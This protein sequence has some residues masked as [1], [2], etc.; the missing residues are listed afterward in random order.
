MNRNRKKCIFFCLCNSET[1]KIP[2]WYLYGRI[3]GKGASI[4]FT[5]GK[6]KTF[7]ES[8]KTVSV[9]GQ[10]NTKLEKDKDF[11]LKYGLVFYRKLGEKVVKYKNEFF[12][13]DDI[14]TFEKNNYFIKDY[15]WE[16]EKEFRIVII[17]KTDRTYDRLKID[18]PIECFK[19]LKI[20]VAPE[21]GDTELTEFIKENKGFQEYL[22]T[23]VLKS[24]LKI[25]MSLLKR[26]VEEFIK[27]IPNLDKDKAKQ[28]CQNIQKINDFICKNDKST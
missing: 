18:I 15:P 22:Q 14:E 5:P 10:E 26:N 8:I 21:V 3:D 9:V 1:E 25:N 19:T 27:Y 12:T 20:R 17:N 2:M 28:I 11:D 13:V 16:Y 23:S 7:I 4:G 6:M 24:S